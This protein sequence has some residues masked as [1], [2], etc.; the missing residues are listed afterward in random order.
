MWLG[1]VEVVGD[2]A[3]RAK[4]RKP[5]TSKIRQV[6]LASSSYTNTSNRQGI[7]YEIR[8]TGAYGYLP[9]VAM[10]QVSKRSPTTHAR[11]SIVQTVTT[12]FRVMC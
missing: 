12:A 2:Q 4:A 9:V 1:G 3:H 7:S 8:V 10:N 5:L 11:R 6:R